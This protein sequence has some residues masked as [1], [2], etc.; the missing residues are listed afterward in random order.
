MKSTKR[1]IAVAAV[2]FAAAV[3]GWWVND[4]QHQ[5]NQTQIRVC[6]DIEDAFGDTEKVCTW[7]KEF[8]LGFFDGALPV[9]GGALG[10]AALLL[11]LDWRERRHNS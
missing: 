6:T 3:F 8:H 10:F 7:K 4:G 9:G 5:A 11:V 2:V 1:I